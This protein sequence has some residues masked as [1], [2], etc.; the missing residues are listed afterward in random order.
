MKVVSGFR[1]MFII[2]FWMAG[3]CLFACNASNTSDTIKFSP[4][5][6]SGKTIHIKYE[7]PQKLN[8]ASVKLLRSVVNLSRIPVYDI[9]TYPITVIP[10]NPSNTT[11]IYVDSIFADG[12]TY[13]YAVF[14]TSPLKRNIPSCSPKI[15]STKPVELPKSLNKN[16][17]LFIDKERYVLEVWSDKRKIK[18]YAICLGSNPHNR[19][20][21]QDR[22]ST[23][24]GVYR[25]T[26][27]NHQSNFNKSYH[28]N[29][30]NATDR[31]RYKTAIG[32]NVIPKNNG[33]VQPIGG[34]ITIHGGGGVI[35]NWTWGCIA[36]NDD[37]INALFKIEAIRVG[38]KVYI[39]GR[40]VS[41]K[42]LEN[43]IS[44]SRN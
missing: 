15:V 35:N 43:V 32:K 9:V 31:I 41:R 26:Y 22:A 40:E 24:E 13:C 23:P 20:L 21:H 42:Q 37:D 25:I 17:Y 29:Y 5:L 8:L 2:T 19:K 27:K 12:L 4:Q 34:S 1:F 14:A 33:Q 16:C 18:S 36:M 10:L 7:L 6:H 30:P 39:S 44:Q 38:T 3:V 28:I 11:G